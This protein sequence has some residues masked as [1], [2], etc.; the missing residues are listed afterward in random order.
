[1]GIVQ[2]RDD[3]GRA[4]VVLVLRLQPGDLV[5]GEDPAVVHGHGAGLGPGGVP[6]PEP[7]VPQGVDLHRRLPSVAAV[8]VP[9]V[10][11]R[12]A[13]PARAVRVMPTTPARVSMVRTRENPMT[14]QAFPPVVLSSHCAM[15]GALPPKTVAQTW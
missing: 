2:S 8:P 5:D 13:V 1:V 10:S 3:P 12:P 15:I 7:A 9:G 6:G 11:G 4:E 14:A